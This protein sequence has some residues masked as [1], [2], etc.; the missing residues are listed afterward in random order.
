LIAAAARF[1]DAFGGRVDV[2]LAPD[3]PLLDGI[4]VDALAGASANAPRTRAARRR[5]ARSVY[6]EPGDGGGVAWFRY[7]TTMWVV[8]VARRPTA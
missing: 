1:E 2:V 5:R 8:D 4:H 7:V 6:A 3:R